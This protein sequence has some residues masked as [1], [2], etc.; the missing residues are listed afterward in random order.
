MDHVDTKE[1]E[2]IMPV[3]VMEL[4]DLKTAFSAAMKIEPHSRP[5]ILFASSNEQQA[6]Y[7]K[8]SLHSISF[9]DTGANCS[10][11]AVTSPLF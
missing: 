9:N 5:V 3:S 11:D 4:Q 2:G 8:P 7:V 10:E 1:I 6:V